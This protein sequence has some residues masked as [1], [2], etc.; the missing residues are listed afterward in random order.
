MS[1]TFVEN[2]YLLNHLIGLI[3][4]SSNE[5]YSQSLEYLTEYINSWKEN[6]EIAVEIAKEYSSKTF[7]ASICAIKNTRRK[8]ED[9]HV[10]LPDLNKALALKVSLQTILIQI[11]FHLFSKK[12]VNNHSFIDFCF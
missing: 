6:P 12:I 7:V 4:I 1:H 2:Q 9:R 8:M 5:L 11:C 10:L 3:A